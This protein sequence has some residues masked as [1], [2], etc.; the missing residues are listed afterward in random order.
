MIGVDSS[1][2]VEKIRGFWLVLRQALSDEELV[3]VIHDH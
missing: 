3:F 2:L 1:V